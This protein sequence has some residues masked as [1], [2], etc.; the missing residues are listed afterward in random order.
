MCRILVF[1]HVMFASIY[2]FASAPVPSARAKQVWPLD[3]SIYD[4]SLS[5][6]HGKIYVYGGREKDYSP[7]NTLSIYDLKSAKVSSFTHASFPRMAGHTSAL[8]GNRLFLGHSTVADFHLG[9]IDFDWNE[10]DSILT[11]P[12]QHIVAMTH[13]AHSIMLVDSNFDVH[14]YDTVRNTA[15]THK[16]KNSP[17]TRYNFKAQA[18]YDRIYI[19]GG[20]PSAPDSAADDLWFFDLATSEW[21][22]VPR[23][24]PPFGPWPLDAKMPW[25]S[26]RT[27]HSMTLVSNK[28][29]VF[30]GRSPETGERKR[31]LWMLDL[32]NHTWQQLDCSGDRLAA[33]SLHAGA[34][35]D[36]NLVLVGG[37]ADKGDDGNMIVEVTVPQ[38][39]PLV[40][41]HRRIIEMSREA[42]GFDSRL[43]EDA[44]HKLIR[45]AAQTLW[46]RRPPT[47]YASARPTTKALAPISLSTGESLQCPQGTLPPLRHTRLV[48]PSSLLQFP[49]PPI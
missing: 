41:R 31:D 27:E 21:T 40:G 9:A 17:K 36:G 8:I 20:S 30:G 39:I 49:S 18:F 46:H 11:L 25:P 47:P 44:A 48:P 4:H 33:V 5:C 12:N 29:Y 37:Y 13:S 3:S 28:I 35:R 38:R 42:V 34:E 43:E 15:T 2:L 23:K 24:A 6:G 22:Q 14:V 26:P 7:T 10:Y 45:P 32:R 16:A 19:F 1:C